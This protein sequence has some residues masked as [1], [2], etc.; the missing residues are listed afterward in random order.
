MSVFDCTGKMVLKFENI[1]QDITFG[2]TL[3]PGIY[4]MKLL[5]LLHQKLSESLSHN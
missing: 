1:F 3:T 2:K 5:L 4:F